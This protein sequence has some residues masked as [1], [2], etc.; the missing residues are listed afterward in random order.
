MMGGV[1][2]IISYF[3]YFK[4]NSSQR[5]NKFLSYILYVGSIGRLNL[6]IPYAN[7]ST[8]PWI[9]KIGDL[10]LTV[11]SDNLVI[12]KRQYF[13]LSIEYREEM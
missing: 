9:I 12:S 11:E 5:F 13:I 7:P 3:D 6:V 4:Y 2:G 1:L 10:S 8:E